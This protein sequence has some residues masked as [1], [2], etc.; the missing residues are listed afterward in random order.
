MNFSQLLISIVLFTVPSSC[1][2]YPIYVSILHHPQTGALIG[3][4]GDEHYN[5]YDAQSIQTEMAF[6]NT[7]SLLE[8][9]TQHEFKVIFESNT[10]IEKR[11]T[12]LHQQNA[13]PTHW[14]GLYGLILKSAQNRLDKTIFI[15]ADARQDSIDFY[16]VLGLHTKKIIEAMSLGIQHNLTKQLSIS[17]CHNEKNQIE[18][19]LL[20]AKT[21]SHST[22]VNTYLY[23][24]GKNLSI[25]TST[26]Q[27]IFKN[28]AYKKTASQPE[29]ITYYTYYNL[30]LN[31]K[32]LTSFLRT[33]VLKFTLLQ[34]PYQAI[35]QQ[36]Q[37]KQQL[38]L[39]TCKK[40]IKTIQQFI[41]LDDRCCES[42]IKLGAH[43]NNNLACALGAIEPNT[44]ATPLATLHYHLMNTLPEFFFTAHTLNHKKAF[45]FTGADHSKHIEHFLCSPENGFKKLYSKGTFNAQAI[46]LTQHELTHFYIT[47]ANTAGISL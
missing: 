21:M 22:L 13:S 8:K 5:P 36:L 37:K 38:C 31:S 16:T 19:E 47:I 14:L 17:T 43:Y 44:S 4:I 27:Q 46:P 20:A 24:L 15:A 10:N 35:A 33:M 41:S 45:V 23:G 28:I 9:C 39:K 32:I 1:L 29:K 40:F 42:I 34:H 6:E 2:A 3:I 12:A 25:S 26:M 11:I 7:K 18:Q 30:L